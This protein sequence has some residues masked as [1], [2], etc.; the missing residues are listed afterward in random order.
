MDGYEV[1][2][3][4]KGSPHTRDIPIIFI[5]AM[6]AV[7]DKVKGFTLGGVDY[8]TKPFRMEEVLARVTTHLA[9]R[10]LQLELEEKNTNLAETNAALERAL[11]EIKTLRGILPIC[12]SCKKIRDDQGYWNQIEV[13]IRSHSQAEF[14]HGICPDCAQKLY[15]DLKP[16]NM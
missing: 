13:Y 14:S 5:S 12:C 1:C 10:S 8:I 6:D 7:E 3:Q 15:P 4:L 2:R 9:L 11:G 16:G